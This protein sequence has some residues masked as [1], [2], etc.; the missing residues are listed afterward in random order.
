MTLRTLARR[1]AALA[2][3]V[4]APAAR[5]Q[6]PTGLQ[7]NGQT[8]ALEMDLSWMPVGAA[9]YRVQISTGRT[10][11][12]DSLVALP[13]G[14]VVTTDTFRVRANAPRLANDTRY[15]W[16]VRTGNGQ[17]WSAAA[18]FT[19]VA[20]GAAPGADYPSAG[21]EVMDTR[22]D[23]AWNLGT[24]GTGFMVHLQVREASAPADW[25]Q[26]VIDEHGLDL[27][28]FRP[29]AGVLRDSTAYVWRVRALV[30]PTSAYW[31]WGTSY[32][33]WRT[34]GASL[35]V[36]FTTRPALVNPVANW[37]SGTGIEPQPPF[38]WFIEMPGSALTYDLE[39]VNTTAG[40]AFTGT[41]TVSG[42]T[43]RAY[44]PAAPLAEGARHRWRVR[45]CTS[46][47]G[48]RCTEWSAPLT[49]TVRPAAA[50]VAPAAS[51]PTGGV[52]VY[53]SPTS[54]SW[55]APGAASGQRYV[56]YTRTCTA[57]SCS[58]APAVSDANTGYDASAP[59][60]ATAHALTTASGTGY[61]WYVRALG[62][63]GTPGAASRRATFR[64]F[65]PAAPVAVPSWPIGNAEVFTV[66]PTLSWWVDGT[67]GGAFEVRY[68]SSA[69]PDGAGLTAATANGTSFTIP[70]DLPWGTRV[71]W[72][73]RPA[74]QARWRSASFT[75]VGAPGSLRPVAASPR[76]GS[77]VYTPTATLGWYVDGHT[78]AV[79][80][81]EVQVSSRSN[82][83]AARTVTTPVTAPT[84]TLQTGALTPGATTYWRV[85]AHNG[86]AWSPWSGTQTFTAD[87]GASAVVPVAASPV[88]Y[89]ESDA[90]PTLSWALPV[91]STSALAFDV[92]VATDEAM[93]A[94]ERLTVDAGDADAAVAVARRAP[95]TYFWRVRSRTADGQMSDFSDVAAFIVYDA[96]QVTGAEASVAGEMHL[97]APM[98]NPV[99]GAATLRFALPSAGD[100][101]LDLLDVTG[102]R[103]A[104][105]AT[106]A[107]AAGPQTVVW[108]GEADGVALAPGV[109]VLRLT[110]GATTRTQPLVIVR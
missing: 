50:P 22:P 18:S 65:A 83:P 46:S 104:V 12:A 101:T 30:G 44:T 107:F 14:G 73:V 106:G 19:T 98:P 6:S 90:A 99:R 96:S 7:P 24:G 13:G 23:F 1:L 29:A 21:L 103:V 57:L 91:V 61:A 62:A 47:G 4:A 16:R 32:R 38:S 97:A 77:I 34:V 10:F 92:E 108:D 95:G 79:S 53:T 11:H 51:W 60:T 31:G 82:F 40:G 54:L 88:G 80:H 86:T 41:P 58:D 102:R 70:D 69:N 37:P 15:F 42:L 93:T 2:L 76:D 105:V 85:R 39:I 67:H 43:A 3:L 17:P 81:Y 87:A 36:P 100:A 74:G 63:D 5:A 35:E 8:T 49:F 72:H 94:P 71:H 55:N 9:S 68:G 48:T 52:T 78:A 45:A 66:R 25:S 27:L 75:T 33:G 26:T 109:Y 64:T 84:T 20:P 110:H 28:R 56:V 59:T 89:G